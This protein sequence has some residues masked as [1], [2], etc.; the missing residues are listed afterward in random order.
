M[1]NIQVLLAVV[2]LATAQEA[3][4]MEQSEGSFESSH[5]D[6]SVLLDV[7]RRLGDRLY[8][9]AEVSGGQNYAKIIQEHVEMYKLLL[10]KKDAPINGKNAVAVTP[11]MAAAFNYQ[12]EIIELLVKAGADIAAV[13]VD[14]ESALD[15]LN[16]RCATLAPTGNIFIDIPH[17][18]MAGYYTDARYNECASLLG[19]KNSK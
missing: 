8:C 7:S 17:I 9:D 11:L 18:V 6:V 12:A 4:A 3:H 13:D 19:M 16:T 10:Q 5:V 2:M 1:K 14:G 15:Y